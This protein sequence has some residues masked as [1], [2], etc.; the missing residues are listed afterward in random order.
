M[1]THELLAAITVIKKNLGVAGV[2]TRE[3]LAVE[4][5]DVRNR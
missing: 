3:Q 1:E 5:L 2:E 4:N